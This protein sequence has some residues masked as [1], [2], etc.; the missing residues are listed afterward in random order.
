MFSVAT[1]AYITSLYHSN[2]QYSNA[3]DVVSTNTYMH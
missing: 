1:L 3:S 2:R